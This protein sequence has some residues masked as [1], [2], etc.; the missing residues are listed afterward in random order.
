VLSSLAELGFPTAPESSLCRGWDE[1]WAAVGAWEERR[2]ELAY[3]T[4]GV[5][6][7]IDSFDQRRTLGVT[8]KF[9]R[10]AI[11]FKFPA[12]QA[13]TP[14]VGLEVNIGR[15]GTVTPVAMLEPVELSG[16]TV[17]RASLHN[18]DQV[19]RL[20]LGVGDRVLVHKAGEIIPQVLS[21]VEQHAAAP[22]AAPTECPSCRSGLV[23]DEGRVALR[24]PNAL[25]CPAQ[26][27]QSIQFFA[28]RGQL[29]IDGLGEKICQALLDAGLVKNVADLFVLREDQLARLD[30]FAETSARNLVASIDR[31]RTTATTSRLLTALGIPHVGGVAARLVARRYRKIDELLQVIDEAGE[32]GA[33]ARIVEIDGIG[34]VIARSLVQFLARPETREVLGQLKER[35]IDPVE[36][37]EDAGSGPLAGKT[38]VITGT[39]SVPRSEIASRI[40]R[41]GGKVAG[42]VSKSTTY[43]VAGENTGES[44]RAAAIKLGVAVL[45]E[46]GLAALLA[47]EPAAADEA[48]TDGEPSVGPPA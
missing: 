30:R 25:A 22:F 46:V 14:V 39:L 36:P 38:F 15:T 3:D 6:I 13:L 28:G 7:K 47:G 16:T 4:D 33:V 45:D 27:L 19:A 12:N 40:Q 29:N 11:A 21:V 1:L 43:L 23:R 20:G 8:S 5:V 32:D 31:A 35:G 24:C 37:A 26:L 41:A 17:K 9:P 48:P 10:W 2:T 42:T 44:K 34:E 18:W